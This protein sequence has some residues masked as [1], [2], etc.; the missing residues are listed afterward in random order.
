MSVNERM[1]GFIFL[2]IKRVR[3]WRW[4]MAAKREQYGHDG[5]KFFKDTNNRKRKSKF[6]KVCNLAN[7]LNKEKQ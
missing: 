4:K 3:I 7:F 5:G 6:I 2:L 1:G